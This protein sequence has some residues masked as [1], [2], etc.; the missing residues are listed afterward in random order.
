M[1]YIRVSCD[2]YGHVYRWVLDY[3]LVQIGYWYEKYRYVV[4]MIISIVHLVRMM[5]IQ[6][7]TMEMECR[8]LIQVDMLSV[9]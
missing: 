3:L 6:E 9:I 5:M 4:W 8:I 1:T 7:M 2:A